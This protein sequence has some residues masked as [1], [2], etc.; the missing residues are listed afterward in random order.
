MNKLLD[1]LSIHSYLSTKDHCKRKYV[2]SVIPNE[3][4]T[5]KVEQNNINIRSGALPGLKLDLGLLTIISGVIFS[6]F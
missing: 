5:N 2:I 3:N 1:P 4:S 6:Y